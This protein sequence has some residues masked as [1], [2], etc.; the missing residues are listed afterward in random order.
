MKD[1][2]SVSIK[3]SFNG[4]YNDQLTSFQKLVPLQL[5]SWDIF[6]LFLHSFLVDGGHI[7]L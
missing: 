3:A 6:V 4:S 7:M 2:A 1:S 5:N